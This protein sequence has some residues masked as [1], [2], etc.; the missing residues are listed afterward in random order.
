MKNNK[1]IKNNIIKIID[2]LYK[3]SGRKEIPDLT[4]ICLEAKLDRQTAIKFLYAWWDKYYIN[5]HKNIDPLNILVNSIKESDK[6]S[7]VRV[8][9]LVQCLSKEIILYNELLNN[10][11]NFTFPLGNY[12]LN[13][14]QEIEGQIFADLD[15]IN[16]LKHS[17][18]VMQEE[19]QH[20]LEENNR[21]YTEFVD[22][23]NK[24]A[25]EINDLNEKL[26]ASRREALAANQKLKS[27]K[28][29]KRRLSLKNLNAYLTS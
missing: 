5:K 14:L 2:N 23:Q 12:I 24:T 21:L 15:H 22:L 10:L 11:P 26:D 28:R 17:N 3:L 8:N 25:K 1:F 20:F 19:L 6:D 4:K 18:K 13:S 7:L 27:L 29:D 16:E 9:A